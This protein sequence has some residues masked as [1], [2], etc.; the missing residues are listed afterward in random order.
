MALVLF[1]SI[2]GLLPVG[3]VV[4]NSPIQSGIRLCWLASLSVGGSSVSVVMKSRISCF[5]LGIILLLQI[6]FLY[7]HMFFND[8]STNNQTISVWRMRCYTVCLEIREELGNSPYAQWKQSGNTVL[9][10]CY[11]DG[12]RARTH[13]CLTLAPIIF[14][15]PGRRRYLLVCGQAPVGF[16][17]MNNGVKSFFVVCVML[18]FSTVG[19]GRILILWWHQ[20]SA[21]WM[22]H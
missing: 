22:H 18:L 4:R 3:A 15:L 8:F 17:T 2:I 11:I 1:S 7:F 20:C 19:K 9:F 5:Y 14:L 21:A 16:G 6:V 13:S 10:S 12:L